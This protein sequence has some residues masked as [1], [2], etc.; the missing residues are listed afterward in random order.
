MGDQASIC[1]ALTWGAIALY[2]L[3]TIA[4]TAGL[5]FARRSWGRRSVWLIS[6][7]MIVHL[8]AI[9]YWWRVVGHGP[10]L[11][12]SEVLS[13]DAWVV[14]AA[15]LVLARLFPAIRPTSII[16]YPV[17]FL[18]LALAILLNP[19]IRS[20]P[21]TYG[22]IWLLFHIAFYKIALGT[23]LITLVLSVFC[24]MERAPAWLGGLREPE[25]LDLYAYRFAGFAFIFWGIGMLAGSIWAYFSWGRYWGWDPIETWSLIS[26]LV[27]AVYLHLRRFFHLKGK[28][29]A[30]LFVFCFVLSVVSYYFISHLWPVSVHS[31]YFK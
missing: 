9:L 17:V 19:G 12:P 24:L 16:V 1:I 26:F 10:Y 21:P 31:E 5:L 11:A 20:L 18:M 2:V 30:W 23:L 22:T 27:I 25:T 3:G 13:S 14:M 15:Y 29:A 28:R 8:L 4:N 7:G 6:A